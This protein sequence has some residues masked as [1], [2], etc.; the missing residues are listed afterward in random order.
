MK[1]IGLAGAVLALIVLIICLADRADGQFIFTW[2]RAIPGGDKV[3]HLVLIGGLAFVVNYA[4]VWRQIKLAGW[5][6][7][8]GSFV[9]LV[10]ATL[11]E[12]SQLL[13]KTRSFDWLDL[14]FDYLGIW[15][16]G[17]L[18]MRLYRADIRKYSPPQ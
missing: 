18:A 8:A 13:L 4:L 10:L 16:F 3:G 5:N 11:E 2:I 9:V 14:F 17:K 6:V 1:R 12:A 15:L 7:L